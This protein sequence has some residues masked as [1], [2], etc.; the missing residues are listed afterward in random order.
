MNNKLGIQNKELSI[1]LTNFLEVLEEPADSPFSQVIR[2]DFK[3]LPNRCFEYNLDK[4]DYLIT[5]IF[6]VDVQSNSLSGALAKLDIDQLKKLNGFAIKF[7]RLIIPHVGE[8][9]P[10]WERLSR[11]VIKLNYAML[12]EFDYRIEWGEESLPISKKS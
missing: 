2:E 8:C 1:L 9:H 3:H 12:K 5:Y 10:R 4:L 6:D 11:Q 7:N